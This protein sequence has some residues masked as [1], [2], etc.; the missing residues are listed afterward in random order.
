MYVA[1]VLSAGGILAWSYNEA[2]VFL[3]NNLSIFITDG[4][5]SLAFPYW[6]KRHDPPQ[7][8]VSQLLTSPADSADP[9]DS[10]V[11]TNIGGLDCCMIVPGQ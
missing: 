10:V 7:M 3:Y 5:V 11:T 9:L 8:G 2:L 4:R 1:L 6:S